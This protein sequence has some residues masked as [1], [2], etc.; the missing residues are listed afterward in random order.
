MHAR[1]RRPAPGPSRS[2]GTRSRS[3]APSRD[4]R[5][6]GR[7]SSASSSSSTRTNGS[8]TWSA[9]SRPVALPRASRYFRISAST[10]LSVRSA[11]AERRRL[12][13][14]ERVGQVLGV[15]L[16][17][18]LV[19]EAL[20]A[21]RSSARPWSRSSIAS[22]FA[23]CRPARRRSSRR[24]SSWSGSVAAT[25]AHGSEPSAARSPRASRESRSFSKAS[26]MAMIVESRAVP[27]VP[28]RRGSRTETLRPAVGRV[29]RRSGRSMDS[30]C[31]GTASRAPLLVRRFSRRIF[32]VAGEPL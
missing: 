15:V 24:R 14:H 29:K 3:S 25:D 6:V 12:D 23:S 7:S 16:L 28:A 2:T 4:G 9:M 19:D 31:N 17:G 30:S 18:G 21:R 11:V 1:S 27:D 26:V 22:S 13:R 10:S 20:G 32:P 5:P 8:L